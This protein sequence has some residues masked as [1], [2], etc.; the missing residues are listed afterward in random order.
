MGVVAYL[1]SG[2]TGLSLLVFGLWACLR[3]PRRASRL[4]ALAG[5]GRCA[6]FTEQPCVV[7]PFARAVQESG[8]IVATAWYLVAPGVVFPAFD[9]CDLTWV[10]IPFALARATILQAKRAPVST[11]SRAAGLRSPPAGGRP[12]GCT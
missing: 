12:S 6:V 3:G 2:L 11:A 10:L 1:A 8:L 5:V 4:L 9:Y 7:S